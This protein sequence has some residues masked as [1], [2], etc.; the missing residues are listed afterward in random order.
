MRCILVNNSLVLLKICINKNSANYFLY[1]HTPKY[2]GTM[3][4]TL[5]TK[6]MDTFMTSHLLLFKF[7]FKKW[8]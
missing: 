5:K 1:C 6:F 8:I 2:I 7:A 4:F 3:H